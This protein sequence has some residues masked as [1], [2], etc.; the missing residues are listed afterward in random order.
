MRY[1]ISGKPVERFLTFLQTGSHK[2]ELL[3]A[4]MLEFLEKEGI[5]FEDYRGQ[6]YDKASNMSSCYTGMQTKL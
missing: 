3:A 5:N 1:G 4:Y 2:A 6:S